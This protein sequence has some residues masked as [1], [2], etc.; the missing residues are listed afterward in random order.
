MAKKTKESSFINMVVVLLAVTAVS[1]ASLA[2]VNS[3]TEAP[4]KKAQESKQQEA[5]KVVLPEFTRLD[6]PIVVPMEEDGENITLFYAYNNDELVGVAVETYSTKGFSG[7]IFILAGFLPDGTIYNTAVLS[8]AETPGLGDKMDAKV[9][10]KFPEQFKGKNPSTFALKVKKDGGDVDAITAATISSR[11][12]AD[13]VQRAYDV[14]QDKYVA[15]VKKS[16]PD[17]LPPYKSISEKVII[18]ANKRELKISEAYDENDELV[19]IGVESYSTGFD[20][21]GV[22]TVMVCFLPNGDIYNSYVVSHSETPGFGDRIE[23]EK[24]D[25]TK[26]FNGKNPE[27]F[28]LK[29][30]K[31]N[32]DVDGYSGATITTNAYA[33]AIQKAYD[34]I[35]KEGLI[36]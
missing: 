27:T 10:P 6:A 31:Y 23:E 16:L 36:K 15:E 17:I 12:F 22:I 19:A 1:A 34:L 21:S 14:W 29:A 28:K 2:Y 5:L 7:K 30:I 3:I 32:G 4:R 35:K 8:H 24:S 25:F 26:Q 20:E 11:A 13:A 18:D 33:E 9:S